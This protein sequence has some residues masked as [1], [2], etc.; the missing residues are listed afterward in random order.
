[1]K[2]SLVIAVVIFLCQGC[3]QTVEIPAGYRGVKVDDGVVNSEVLKP[4]KHSMIITQVVIFDV[5]PANFDEEFDFLFSDASRGDLRIAFEYTPIADS[6]SV[7]YREYDSR[8]FELM[9]WQVIRIIPRQLLLT[10]KPTDLTRGEFKNAIREA[11]LKDP[12]IVKYIKIE[13]FDILELSY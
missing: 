10:Y 1:M 9:T 2:R 5:S 11:I 12:R 13:K 6:V 7:F 8:D 4:G 3:I